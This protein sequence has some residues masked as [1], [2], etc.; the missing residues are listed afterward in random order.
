M[1][2]DKTI[3]SGNGAGEPGADPKDAQ[4]TRLRK[5]YKAVTL[6]IADPGFLVKLDGRV[7]KTPAKKDL[8][9]P[10]Q[11]IAERIRQEW[12]SQGEY[13]D[14]R[15]MGVTKIANSALDFVAGKESEVVDELCSYAAS[16]LICYFA[17]EPEE[18]VSLQQKHWSP[19]HTWLQ[20]NL[21]IRLNT[22]S[23]LISI[24]QSE[25]DLERFRKEVEKF[26]KLTLSAAH[27]ATTLTGSA[28]LALVL[29]RSGLSVDACWTA[30]HVDE[31]WQIS[32]WGQD[33]EATLRRKARKAEFDCASFL[34]KALTP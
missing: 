7:L 11:E 22:A 1:S 15:T 27:V 10:N 9:L 16:D 19:V 12:E 3:K 33:E 13:I 17:E 23:G 29:A 8:V 2:G 4:A 21:D 14:V 31:D 32:K 20:E 18:L 26:D 30:A 25:D 24:E 34:L 28:F 6:D 5:F